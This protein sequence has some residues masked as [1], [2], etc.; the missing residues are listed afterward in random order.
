VFGLDAQT[1]LGLTVLGAMVTT[2]GNLAAQVLKDYALVRSFE[3]WKSRQL[4]VSVFHRYRDPII[5]SAS[6]LCYRLAEINRDYPTVFLR[7][8]LLNS[9]PES[10][11]LNSA[12]DEYFQRYKFVSTVY[13]LCAFLGWIELYRQDVTFL[14]GGRRGANRRFT[15]ALQAFQA[16]LADGQLNNASDW[17]S[18]Q[19]LLIFREEQRAIGDA[20]I[21][22]IGQSRSVAGYGAFCA[23]LE[24]GTA[25]MDGRW[26]NSAV[27]FLADLHDTKDFRRNRLHRMTVHLIDLIE[28]LDRSRITPALRA[29]KIDAVRALT[30][31]DAIQKQGIMAPLD[32]PAGATK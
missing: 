19:D 32:V 27:N 6:E 24:S 11:R 17:F 14:D 20:M 26:I 4:L 30:S 1:L 25:S 3:R 16:D 18:W 13:R 21:R 22:S 8:T 2:G 29:A 10:L 5:L 9:R 7:R 23:I 15:E 28:R 12:E 31:I